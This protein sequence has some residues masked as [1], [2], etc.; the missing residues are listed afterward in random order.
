MVPQAKL[1]RALHPAVG[2]E[3][4]SETRSSRHQASQEADPCVRTGEGTGRNR[5]RDD[6]ASPEHGASLGPGE[7]TPRPPDYPRESTG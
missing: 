6:Q 3:L 2:E 1:R 5:K 4:A 7:E